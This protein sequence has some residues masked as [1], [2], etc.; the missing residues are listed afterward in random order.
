MRRFRGW[1][2]GALA[3]LAGAACGD[4]TAPLDGSVDAPPTLVPDDVETV[5]PETVRAGQ[6]LSISCLL[7][8]PSGETFTPPA[9][10]EP[11]LRFV[12]EASVERNEDGEW[13]AT[14]VGVVEVSC[15]FPS[16]RLSDETPARIDVTPGEPARVVTSLDLDSIEAGGTVR[17]TCDVYDAYGNR[18]EDAS[19]TVRAEPAEDGNSFEDSLGSFTKAGFFDV[20]CELPGAESTPAELE[21]RPSIPASLVISRVPDQPIYAIGQVIEIARVVAD[22]YGNP[23]PDAVVPVTSDPAGQRLGDGRFRY[24]EDGRYELTATVSGPTADGVPLSASTVVIVDGNGPAIQCDDPLDGAILDR[25]PGGTITFRGSVDDLSGVSSVTVN[26]TAVAVDAGGAFTHDLTTHY[27][28]NFVDLTA[29]DGTGREA[30][31][32]CAFLVADVWG[33]D[34]ATL[35]DTLSLR[36][37]QP[38]FDDGARGGDLNSLGDILHTVLNSSGLRD[39]LHTE[40]RDNNPLKPSSCDQSVL[41]VCVLRSEVIYQNSELRGPNTTSLDLVDGGLRADVR[42]ENVRIRIRVRGH[43]SG[44]PYDTE[45][46]VTFSHL[47]VRAIFDVGIS[48]GRP[49]ITVRPG[50]V[51]T[52]VGSIDTSFSGLDGGIVNIVVDLFQGTVRNLISGLV[53]DWV[54]DNF[55][56]ILDGLVGGLDVSSLGTRFDVP[57]LDSDETIP[58]TFGLGFSTLNATSSRAL[59]GIG[60]RFFAPA[61]HARPTLGAPVRRGAR[62]LDVGGSGSTAVAVHEAILNQALHALWRG[63]FFDANLDTDTLGGDGLPAGVSAELSTGLPPVAVITDEDRVEMSLGA[64]VMRLDYPELF[65]EPINLTLGVRASLS[66]RLSGGDTLIFEGFRIEELYFSTDLASLDMSTRDTIE[67]FLTR[68]LERII[69]PALMDAL[70]ALPIPTFEIPPSLG[71]YGL[72]VGDELGVVSPALAFE[73]PHFVLRGEFAVR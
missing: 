50:S 9:T 52:D 49:Q 64:M 38:A 4:G 67:G 2:F 65:A 1:M 47:G 53:R 73:A 71:T 15:V 37:R 45:G 14:Q 35:S 18:V 44:I 43:V 36:L 24:L 8:D 61:A 28:I 41:G 62:L 7:V 6:E 29:T 31:R 30:S 26:G 23:I 48:G 33:P 69:R 54:T 10:L 51:S 70:P 5:A 57:R 66:A 20:Y 13:I 3:L 21:V 17:T 25:A 46:W 55:N 68:L 58:L 59:F 42:L 16:L 32:T 11:S 39:T 40:L 72:P 22:R 19:P 56:S 60:T 27:G 34:D 12:P 63:G